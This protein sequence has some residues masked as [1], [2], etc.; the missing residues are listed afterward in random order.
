MFL[1]NY[2]S[3]WHHFNTKYWWIIL[4]RFIYCLVILSI[5]QECVWSVNKHVGWASDCWGDRSVISGLEG[6]GWDTW[7]L[8]L[9][10]L[11]Q[12]RKP[13]QGNTPTY[14]NCSPKAC[15]VSG[16]LKNWSVVK[17]T[18]AESR[19][20]QASSKTNHKVSVLSWIKENTNLWLPWASKNSSSELSSESRAIL[21]ILHS[22][23]L[24]RDGL[25]AIWNKSKEKKKLFW[26]M[27]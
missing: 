7:H 20:Q 19:E 18:H 15:W 11:I 9:A 27:F 17:E 4:D 8:S 26:G 21:C 16:K 6:S 3:L 22:E 2:L 14:F 23:M 13:R 5:A 10:K 1:F 25:A 12:H 24:W